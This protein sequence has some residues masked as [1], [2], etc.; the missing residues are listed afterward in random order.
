MKIDNKY[1]TLTLTLSLK[2]KVLHKSWSLNSNP[3]NYFYYTWYKSELWPI[4]KLLFLER[5]LIFIFNPIIKLNNYM[6][7]KRI[8]W[9]LNYF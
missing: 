9:I 4:R 5:I 1:I 2:F 7:R 3:N 8:K 6:V